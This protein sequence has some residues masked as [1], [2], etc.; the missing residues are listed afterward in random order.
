MA[1]R[2]HKLEIA[3]LL[4]VPALAIWLF[5]FDRGS[6]T[7]REAEM[8]K[9]NLLTAFRRDQIEQIAFE[10]EGSSFRLVKRI[11]DGDAMYYVVRDGKEEIADQTAVDRL[12]SNLEFAVPD[13]KLDDSLEKDALGLTTPRLRMKLEMGRMQYELVL[14]A[15]APSPKGAAYAE[16]RGSGEGAFVLPRDLVTQ[17]SLS[18]NA[19]RSRTLLPYLSPDLERLHIDGP[20]GERHFVRGSWGGWELDGTPR[21]RADREMLDRVLFTFADIRAEAFVEDDE[22]DRALAE[23]HVTI[24]MV[25]REASRPKGV[26][27]IGGECPGQP[28]S[29]VVV[30]EEPS[31][32]S[33]CAPKGVMRSL[34]IPREHFEDKH[35]F[36]FRPD[37]IEELVF[38]EGDRKLELAR[39]GMGWQMRAPKDGDVDADAGNALA[40]TLHGLEALRIVPDADREALGFSKPRALAT[41]SRAA[42]SDDDPGAEEV[43]EIGA[44]KGNFVYARRKVDDAV[45]ELGRDVAR[46]LEP[47]LAGLQSRAIVNVPLARVSKVSVTGALRQTIER[48]PSG[49]WQLTTPSG[50]ETD[51]AIAVDVA[52]ALRT[53]KADRWVSEKDDGSFGL[54]KPRATYELEVEN[55]KGEPETIRILVGEAAGGGYFAKREGKDGVFVLP[56]ALARRIESYAIDRAYFLVVPKEIRK[57]ALRAK[58]KSVTLVRSGERFV[59][60]GDATISAER[61]TSIVE[62]LADLRIEGVVSLGAPRKE[63]GFDAP[64][65]E[66]EIERQLP[67]EL[68]PETLKI[69]VGAGDAHE[70]MLIHYARR[71]GV[72]ATFAMAQAQ[73]RA[74]LDSL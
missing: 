49:V 69:V 16:L 9:R 15:E 72:D 19:Y 18:E 58:G 20:G 63:E 52:E 71:A 2:K 29:V 31:R 34:V 7:T 62:E 27:K 46:A 8:R 28:E 60:E 41:V 3:L 74:I 48:S 43:V 42:E 1:L 6:L 24:T 38:T 37:E 17:L 35:L 45:L 68:V 61:A 21:I 55:E 57:V 14:G 30:R 47:N 11:E 13:R 54:Q 12:I 25:P 44:T 64:R 59:A 5:F 67:H 26:I 50:Y 39:K 73:V 23:D 33:A 66:V 10:R 70:G 51:A 53:L 32:I 36:S 4:L 65:L 40:R 56:R 22:A